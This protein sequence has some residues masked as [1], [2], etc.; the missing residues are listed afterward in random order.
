MPVAFSVFARWCAIP[1]FSFQNTVITQKETLNPLALMPLPPLPDPQQ[2]PL[3]CFLHLWIWT[4]RINGILQY[5]AF[6]VWLLSLRIMFLRFISVVVSVVLHSF[7]WLSNILYHICFI[8]LSSDR[9]WLVSHCLALM[10]S[11]AKNIH[12]Q[13][14]RWT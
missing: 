11:A 10:N 13:V 12:V 1:V 6:R 3:I 5:V 9:R 4:F 14:F 2:L 8:H 7:L